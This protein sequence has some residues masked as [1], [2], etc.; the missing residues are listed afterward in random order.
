MRDIRK[1]LRASMNGILSARMRDAGMPFRL[2]FGTELPRLESIASEFPHDAE[3]A[4]QL[5]QTKIRETRLLAIMLMPP[6]HFTPPLA[7]LWLS[8]LLTAEE[9]QVMALRLLP[10][11]PEAV[12]TALRTLHRDDTLQIIAAALTLRHLIVGGATM[13]EETCAAIRS[14]L[15]SLV[16]APSLSQRKALRALSEAIEAKKGER[17]EGYLK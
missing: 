7:E 17:T 3:L 15:E 1:E 16:D 13:S 4:Q 2:I 12:P 9:A 10:A 14:R 11:A 8:S 5:W 6:H